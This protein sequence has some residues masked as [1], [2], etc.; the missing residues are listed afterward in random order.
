MGLSY[1]AARAAPEA[2]ALATPEARHAPVSTD[3]RRHAL[4]RRR[5]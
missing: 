5:R 3:T 1:G 4:A 2:R